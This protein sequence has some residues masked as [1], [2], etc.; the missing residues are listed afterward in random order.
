MI[1]DKLNVLIITPSLNP[2]DNISGIS[3]ITELLIKSNDKFHYIPFITGKRD[4]EKRGL[5]WF[6]NLLRKPVMLLYS[7]WGRLD[8]IHFNIGFEPK[9]IIRDIF[10]FLI[11]LL[12]SIPIIL[13]IHGGRFMTR[14]AGLFHGIINFLLKRSKLVIVLS[15]LE[16]D[17]LLE[18]YPEI[19]VDNIK[20]VPN[21][22]SV[23]N[24]TLED[25]SFGGTLSI[26]FLGRIDR[27]KGL[28]KIAESLLILKQKGVS[29]VFYLCGVG[30]DKDWFMNLLSA[31]V[32]NDVVDLGLV[33][34]KQKQDVLVKSHIYILP[35]D[36]EGLP[37]SLLESMGNFVV[38]IVSP[39]G[40]IPNVVNRKN[41]IIVS[42]I[43]EIVEAIDT[44]NSN[45]ELLCG[46]AKMSRKTVEDDFSI[47]H[48]VDVINCLYVRVLHS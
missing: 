46:L 42:T 26:L 4:N 25:K 22:I 37:L 45:R 2:L 47:L 14:E 31:A 6:L 1:K 12:R 35:S 30:P 23:P 28:E 21:A 17:F 44:L 48:F 5:F 34:G 36:F 33:Y 32:L 8:L 13:H 27:A 39:V 41:G 11:L 40:S 38:P 15:D 16:K 9:S 20:V 7:Y 19:L 24:V 18:Y 43:E 10:L 29:F 3:T